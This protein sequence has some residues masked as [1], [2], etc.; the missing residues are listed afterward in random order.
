MKKIIKIWRLSEV[1]LG[2]ILLF[3]VTYLIAKNIPII[4]S[5]IT[6]KSFGL[7]LYWY[8]LTGI[9][10]SALFCWPYCKS[11]YPNDFSNNTLDLDGLRMGLLLGLSFGLLLGILYKPIAEAGVGV[12]IDFIWGVEA[13]ISIL[14]GLLAR[15]TSGVILGII[16][17]VSTIPSFGLSFGVFYGIITTMEAGA[18]ARVGAIISAMLDTGV[19]P[20]TSIIVGFGVGI[21]LIFGL[22]FIFTRSSW[23][24]MGG[25]LAGN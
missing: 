21:I 9:I 10:Y 12:H 14:A 23:K 4:G 16:V 17:G 6:L 7:P 15:I 13:T 11:Y 2:A 5:F 24:K 20:G 18:K 3:L 19:I 1:I 8:I 25:W 22:K